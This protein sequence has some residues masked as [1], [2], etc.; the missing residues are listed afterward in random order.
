MITRLYLQPNTLPLQLQAPSS[1]PKLQLTPDLAM[2]PTL[3]LL[4]AACAALAPGAS[5]SA[6][7]AF[8][9]R[10]LDF[11]RLSG[12][13]D[14]A[15]NAQL[16][17]ALQAD[18]ILALRN[19]P[20]YAELRA[21]YLKAA[22]ECAV[23]AAA[24]GAEFLLHRRLRDETQRFTIS[25]ES[26]R[27][28]GDLSDGQEELLAHCP[29]YQEVYERFSAVVEAAVADVGS[30][31][32]A[33]QQFTV[34]A[35]G[36]TAML[37]RKLM[38]ES[39]H[40]DHFH[41]YEAPR[42]LKEL[43]DDQDAT[44]DLSLEMHTDNGLM[45]AMSAPEYFDV[46]PSGEVSA[47]HTRS[48]D[49]G[50]LIQTADG[51]VAAPLL[52]ADELVLMLGS[53]INQWIQTSPPLRPVLHGMR[54]PRGLSYADGSEAGELHKLLRAWFG[55][56]VLLESFQVMANTGMTYGEYANQTTR[57]LLERDDAGEQFAA[58]ACPPQ[59][60][61]VA[62]DSSC[63]LKTCT[64]KSSAAASALTYS[65]QVTC[66]HD[67]TDDAKLCDKYCDCDDGTETGT[68][69]WMLC[70]ANLDEDVCPGTQQC[71]NAY[72]E[73]TLAMECVGGTVAPTTS[74][75]TSTSTSKSSSSGSSASASASAGTVSS[76]PAPSTATPS[77]TAPAATAASSGSSSSASADAAT[78]VGDASSASA[79]ASDASDAS[80]SD[81]GSDSASASSSASSSAPVISAASGVVALAV[82]A[83]AALA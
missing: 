54:Y 36:E 18:G 10:S 23:S 4:L 47:K 62:S 39:V 59:R 60:Q 21:A 35:E 27:R 41:A 50:L 53:G 7:A 17:A 6:P 79:S 29:G 55:K 22:A 15:Y 31:L 2:R 44:D 71:N 42:A 19:V 16:L 67:S 83:L 52:R 45:I 1:K 65:C 49:A 40:L 38:E 70:V 56:M 69:C 13:A 78:D 74:T 66:N 64:A 12:A 8:S 72:T 48:E 32:D 5:S 11:S 57:Y 34:V 76:T 28:L 68:T 20:R 37:A 82:A 77:T 26:G 30:A 81:S 33:T 9:L 24:G 61:L 43:A 58:V 75:S 3:A 51:Q 73:D 63:S 25:R 80:A 14:N 46:A